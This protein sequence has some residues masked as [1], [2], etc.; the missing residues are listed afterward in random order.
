[1]DIIAIGGIGGIIVAAIAV[2][3]ALSAIAVVAALLANT[4]VVPSSSSYHC[5]PITVL[6]CRR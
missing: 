6:E 2:A 1:M 5:C 4:I 3:V